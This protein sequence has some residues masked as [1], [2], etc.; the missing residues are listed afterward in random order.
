[1]P[2]GLLRDDLMYGEAILGGH[3]APFPRLH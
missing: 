2:A 3:G 1:M